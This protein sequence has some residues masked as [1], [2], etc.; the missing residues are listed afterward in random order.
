MYLFDGPLCGKGRHGFE[1]RL[2]FGSSQ[3]GELLPLCAIQSV[4]HTSR[5]IVRRVT[6]PNKHCMLQEEAVAAGVR[7]GQGAVGG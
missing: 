3:K 5:F 6:N 2:G 1:G 4:Q 7:Q